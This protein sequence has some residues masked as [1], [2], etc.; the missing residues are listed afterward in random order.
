MEQAGQVVTDKYGIKYPCENWI[1][2]CV[3]PTMAPGYDTYIRGLGKELVSKGYHAG[4]FGG[5]FDGLLK[6]V[7]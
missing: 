6:A 1:P 5:R 7:R 4:D 2:L 3:D